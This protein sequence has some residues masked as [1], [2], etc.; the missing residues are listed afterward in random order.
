[1]GLSTSVRIGNCGLAY[2]DYTSAGNTGPDTSVFRNL[3]LITVS[4]TEQNNSCAFF[5]QGAGGQPYAD[6]FKNIFYRT[7]WGFT[8]VEADA[9]S[10]GN[11]GALG[12]LNHFDNVVMESTIPLVTYDGDWTR[13][14][15]GQIAY[16]E[17]GP[18]ILNYGA[19]SNEYVASDWHIENEE[20]EVQG[21]SS[22]LGWRIDGKNHIITGTALGYDK[23]P[24]PVGCYELKMRVLLRGWTFR[25]HKPHW[26]PEQ[27]AIQRWSRFSTHR[28]RHGVWQSLF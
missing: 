17:Y 13:W 20:W 3:R 19:P 28:K 24:S 11:N 1:M 4:G 16:A 6:E 22:G 21:F 15:G 8:A 10:H 7:Y 23:L 5:F 25:D 27:I 18:Q 9:A 14:N 26:G 2:D 12:D